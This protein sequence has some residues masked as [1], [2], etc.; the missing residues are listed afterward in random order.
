[1]K[2]FK[3][4]PTSAG[5][6]FWKKKEIVSFL[7]SILVF[8][9]HISSIAQY[10]QIQDSMSEINRFFSKVVHDCFTKYAVPLYFIIAGALFFR[11]YEDKK[12]V[13]KLKTRIRSIL[14]PYLVWNTLW[15]LFDIITSYSF[16]SQ[17]FIARE[18]FTLSF[19]SVLE[20]IF[21]H[22]CNGAF[23]FLFNL[24]FFIVLSP[25]IDKLIRNRYIGIAVTAAVA[26][27]CLFHIG[28]PE[29]VFFSQP[30][31]V[32]YLI[33][34]IIGKH[35]FEGFCKKSSRITQI[36]SL[37]ILMG[38]AVL[39]YFSGLIQNTAFYMFILVPCAW[40]FWNVADL[41]VH[42]LPSLTI[43]K[44]SFAIY[45]MHINVSSVIAKSLFLL[46]PKSGWMA[47]P[48]FILTLV[49]T[50]LFIFLFCHTLNKWLPKVYRLMI[51][52]R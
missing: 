44:N 47:I 5:A 7:L 42:R 11:D 29:A 50:L 14:I 31:I 22:K 8:F 10:G 36:I 20:A 34:A 46:L 39:F 33:G 19:T 18:K 15:M 16:L 3:S 17:F 52:G 40:A 32:Y 26:V 38:A 1:M 35:Y 49:L 23:W 28:L 51:G 9:I 43:Y 27:L 6:D 4:A 13:D 45:A 2:P 37:I 30:S 12:Y 25:V 21:H 48:N 41:F 24:M